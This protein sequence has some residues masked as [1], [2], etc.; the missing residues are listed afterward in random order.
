MGTPLSHSTILPY[1][2]NAGV[3]SRAYMWQMRERCSICVRVLGSANKNMVH[4]KWRYSLILMGKTHIQFDSL[5]LYRNY[6]G[7]LVSTG[8]STLSGPE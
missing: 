5:Q 3:H 8:L 1:G 6:H 4:C 7:F 2:F